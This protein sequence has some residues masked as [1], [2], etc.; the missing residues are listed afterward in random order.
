MKRMFVAFVALVVGLSVSPILTPTVGALSPPTNLT[1]TAQPGEATLSWTAVD[2]ADGY[3]VYRDDA[4]LTTVSDTTYTDSVD[5]AT[6]IYYVTAFDRANNNFSPKSNRVSVD[7]T[8]GQGDPEQPD[9]DEP[10]E[11]ADTPSEPDAPNTPRIVEVVKKSSYV[12][13]VWVPNPS[14]KGVNVYKN[15]Q[16][17]ASVNAPGTVYNDRTGL[18]GDVYYV[19]AYGEG[20]TFSEKTAPPHGLR[21]K[22]L[23]HRGADKAH[24]SGL[25]RGDLCGRSAGQLC[26]RLPRLLT[27]CLDLRRHSS[28]HKKR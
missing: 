16:F 8:G 25:L 26:R 5:P 18:E 1:A 6:Y 7:A 15:D 12:S 11:P 4:Y 27:P 24:H 23:H 20:N 22:R 19:I 3:N 14:A 2:D 21:R 10:S 28:H 9:A 13:V 17:L